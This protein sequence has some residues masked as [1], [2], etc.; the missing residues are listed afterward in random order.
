MSPRVLLPSEAVK[1]NGHMGSVNC[2]AW[3]PRERDGAGERQVKP[4]ERQVL[5]TSSEDKTIRL[6]DLRRPG[7]PS[8]VLQTGRAV[9][10]LAWSS[11]G[12]LLATASTGKGAIWT[13]GGVMVARLEGHT[14]F[15]WCIEFSRSGRLV[16]TSSYDGT[17]RV[18]EA[19]TGVC[20]QVWTE[21]DNRYIAW[22][23]EELFQ[24]AG[25]AI[26][27]RRIGQDQPV[28]TFRGHEGKVIPL[29]WD[30]R[31][32]VLASGG[33][34]CT[35]RTWRPASA[36]PALATLAGHR[37][38]V[39]QVVWH[40]KKPSILASSDNDGETRIWDTRTRT[41]LHTLPP[42]KLYRYTFSDYISFSPDGELL[43]AGGRKEVRAWRVETGELA[44]V[45]E[46]KAEVSWSPEGNTL[47]IAPLGVNMIQVF[48]LELRLPLWSKNEL[49]PG[50]RSS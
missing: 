5:A 33:K 6:W 49:N 47:A 31:G 38:R 44:L 17:C 29:A 7:A 16:A 30:P 46:R 8:L 32:G 1:L 35:V 42:S 48:D 28:Q 26:L 34:D 15:I 43:A 11:D 3:Q 20:L 25:D 36:S 4:K 27:H 23:G 45:Y 37:G 41:C 10:C 40:P 19:E 21:D 22:K 39:L 18:W 50:D 13:P 2:L 9:H 24:V 12:R 14:N